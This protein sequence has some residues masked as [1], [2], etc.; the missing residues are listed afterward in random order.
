MPADCGGERDHPRGGGQDRQTEGD[1]LQEAYE[2][3]EAACSS[4]TH[5]DRPKMEQEK[6]GWGHLI[7][8]AFF[9]LL[10]LE[11]RGKF[12]G[13]LKETNQTAMIMVWRCMVKEMFELEDG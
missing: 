7:Y 9:I 6:E 10:M 8:S 5:W 12:S 4:P 2:E 3:G 11:V 13:T 1:E